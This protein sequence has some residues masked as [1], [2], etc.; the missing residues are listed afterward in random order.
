M[1]TTIKTRPLTSIGNRLLPEQGSA[2]TG[3]IVLSP[4]LLFD[5]VATLINFAL[6]VINQIAV[7]KPLTVSEQD[8]VP[9]C[10]T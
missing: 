6:F 2:A 5:S 8:A 10:H 3:A 1:P 4:L 9:A 7:P